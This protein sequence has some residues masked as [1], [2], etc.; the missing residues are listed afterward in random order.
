MPERRRDLPEFA[1]RGEVE[2]K[3]DEWEVAITQEKIGA[4]QRLFSFGATQ[5][6]EAAATSITIG[7]GVEGVAPIDERE[8]EVTFFGEELTQH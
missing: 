2:I 5:P 3:K 6:D 4:L 1:F 8:R 7:G